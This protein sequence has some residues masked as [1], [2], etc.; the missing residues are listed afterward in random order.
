MSNLILMDQL[1]TEVWEI[2][3]SYVENA[4][5]DIEAFLRDRFSR[6]PEAEKTK[7][8]E[9]LVSEFEG[10]ESL[11]AGSRRLDTDAMDQIASLLFGKKMSQAEDISSEEMARRLGESLNTIFDSLNHLIGLINKT[12]YGSRDTDR[13]IRQVIGSQLTEGASLKSLEAH[14]G[15]ISRAFLMVQQAFKE[16]AQNQVSRIL[17]AIEPEK[18]KNESKGK[19]NFGPLKK[20]EYFEAY[21]EKFEKVNRWFNSGQFMEDFLREFEKKCQD[22]EKR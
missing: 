10:A 7:L 13:T 8:L 9:K 5:A 3:A 2:Y 21:K 17:E 14:L 22:L 18:I 6:L 4:E 15:Q 20:A 12:L 1:A 19:I 11:D 16:T